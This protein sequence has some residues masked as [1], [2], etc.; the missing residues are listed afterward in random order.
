MNILCVGDIV[1]SP[2]RRIFASVVPELR[3][4]YNVHAVIV[5]GENA[6][7]GR[8]I[9][10]ALA[11]ELFAAGADVITLGDHVWDQKEAVNLLAN[12]RRVI[13]PANFGPGCPGRGWTEFQTSLGPVAVVNLMGRTFMNPAENPFTVADSLLT[14]PIPR[15][16][17]VLFDFHA[18]ATS[19]KI[20]FG[21]YVD[22]R[23]AAVFGTHTHVQ[24]ADA[25]VLPGG[26]GFITDVGMCGPIHSVIGRSIEPVTK[27]FLS[28]MPT[29]FDVAGGP[30]L[31][32]ACLFEIDR[33]R[34][35][36]TRAEAILLRE[37]DPGQA[38]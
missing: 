9:T 16:R 33:Q 36:C 1:G 10:G 17:I 14:G 11:E 15:D 29:R 34:R 13:R 23:A 6:A 2:G 26:T 21:H 32:S 8:G 18:E 37:D 38:R 12:D 4:K 30:A 5:N 7:A 35:C 20:C 27:R 28:G 22:G 25:A 19:E 31:F 24:T 3:R